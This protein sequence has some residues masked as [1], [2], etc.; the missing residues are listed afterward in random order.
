MNQKDRTRIKA[1]IQRR[2]PA[3]HSWLVLP[4]LTYSHRRAM[5]RLETV[6]AMV[7]E[8]F[9]PV[10]QDGPFKGLKYLPEATNSG[11][12]PKILGCYES[13]IQHLVRQEAAAGYEV[14]VDVGCAEGYYAAG[15][16]MASAGCAVYAYD[17]D[18]KCRE[19]CSRLAELNGV[20]S[21]VHVG[22]ECDHARLNALR[23][24]SVLILCD[25]EG[26]ELHLLDPAAVP[27]MAGW[28]IL[29]EL[30]DSMVP[31]V[32][33][34]IVGRFQATHEIELIDSVRRDPDDFPISRF[35]PSYRDRFL[36]V[37]DRRGSWQQWA[38]MRVRRESDNR[39]PS[40]DHRLPASRR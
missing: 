25:C 2:L 8:R 1:F 14:I 10:V 23:A 33:E 20:S 35:L 36:A 21:R 31:G 9:G 29:V 27:A 39:Q 17:I 19:L 34:A 18:P 22:A 32:T 28:D 26:F 30:H 38:W 5:R 12:T 37:S 13:E 16:A 11:L 7:F 24:T 6:T 3:L 4:W 40:T 15:F